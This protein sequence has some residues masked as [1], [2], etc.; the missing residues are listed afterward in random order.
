MTRLGKLNPRSTNCEAD[1]LT[2]TPS[3]RHDDI[4]VRASAS[5][6]VNQGSVIFSGY[7]KLFNMLSGTEERLH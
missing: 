3:R 4:D 5:Q 6:T 2:T 7:K 1:A